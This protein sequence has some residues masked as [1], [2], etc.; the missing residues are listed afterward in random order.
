[1]RNL[2]PIRST[3][4]RECPS[5][6]E[7]GGISRAGLSPGRSGGG[8]PGFTAQPARESGRIAA[9]NS[10][11][12]GR[13]A[14]CPSE[15]PPRACCWKRRCGCWWI[16]R[17]SMAI[18]ALWGSSLRPPLPWARWESCWPRPSIPMSAAGC[19]SPMASEIEAQTIRW[20][21]EMIGY[22]REAGGIAGDGRHD[23][24]LCGVSGRAQSQA[25]L[26]CAHPWHGR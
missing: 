26:G 7:P 22:P 25:H 9:R 17:C 1:M 12:L 6:D 5:G 21:A 15:G 4:P 14:I 18:R 11:H 13:L 10:G 2:E 20:I 19:L 24:Q 23:G 3:E 16:I 8:I